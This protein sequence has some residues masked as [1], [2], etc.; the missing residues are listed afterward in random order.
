MSSRATNAFVAPIILPETETIIFFSFDHA[1]NF[2]QIGTH[3]AFNRYTYSGECIGMFRLYFPEVHQVASHDGLISFIPVNYNRSLFAMCTD[4]LSNKSGNASCLLRFDEK[5]NDLRIWEGSE[6]ELVT[7]EHEYGAM[8]WW[9]DICYGFKSHTA[10][11]HLIAYRGTSDT[12]SYRPIILTEKLDETA[13]ANILRPTMVN[14]HYVIRIFDGCAYV[15]F[16]DDDDDHG[17]GRRPKENGSFFDIGEVE[18]L[19]PFNNSSSG[20]REEFMTIEEFTA[21]EE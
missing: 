5:A 16:F 3:L 11:R 8:A 7:D 4:F 21:M 1:P 10:L 15:L 19:A 13:A 14:G 9:N 2:S 18:V 17:N 6:L 20:V 12:Q